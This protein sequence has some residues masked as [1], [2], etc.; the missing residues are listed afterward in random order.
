[1]WCGNEPIEC[2]QDGA[3]HTVDARR[4]VKHLKWPNILC[5]ETFLSM[6]CNARLFF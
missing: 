2:V 6:C 1:M 4:D 5:E 3:C